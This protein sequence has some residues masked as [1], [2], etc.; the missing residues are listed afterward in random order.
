LAVEFGINGDEQLAPAFG[1]DPTIGTAHFGP[2]DPPPRDARERHIRMESV[3]IAHRASEA[4]LRLF[5]A[6]VEHEECPWLA[7]VVEE[8]CLVIVG[9]G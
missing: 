4:L 3:M 9:S 5:F 2:Q 6:H 1:A 8:C 7:G